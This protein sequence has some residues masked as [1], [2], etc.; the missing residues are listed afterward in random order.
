MIASGLGQ[1]REVGRPDCG[2]ALTVRNLG[3]ALGGRRS[4]TLV[5]AWRVVKE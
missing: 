5:S 3:A 1:L 4:I 2:G